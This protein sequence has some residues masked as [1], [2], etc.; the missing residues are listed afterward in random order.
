MI[1]SIA[2]RSLL[3]VIA[4]F[5][6][7]APLRAQ[8]FTV[9]ETKAFEKSKSLFQKGKYDKAI[10]TLNKVLYAHVHDAELWQHRVLFEKTRYDVEF[11][12]D[13]Q[14]IVK[15]ASKAG[16][17]TIDVSK[18]KSL[19]YRDE[20]L[21]ACYG[22][23]LYAPNQDLASL[24][25]HEN[26]IEPSVDTLISDEVKA[27]HDK[28]LQAQ[29]DKDNAEAMRQFEKAFRMDTTYYTAAVNI[30]YGYYTDEKFDKAVE[31]FRKA[32]RL[33][34]EM[35]EPH[36]YLVEI[37][38]D[39]KDWQ[40]A[41]DACLDAMIQYPFTGYFTRMERICENLNKTFKLHWMER[42]YFPAIATI[43]NQEQA[44]EQPWS[45]YTGAKDK[46]LGY[47]NDDGVVKKTNT[48]T[49]S[50]YMEVYSWE[51]MLKKSDED[52]GE[53]GFA[54]RQQEQGNLDCF[55]MFSMYHITFSAQYTHF[56]DNNR[57]RLKEYIETQLVR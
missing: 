4:V 53:M 22:A 36:F 17:A 3:F 10:T 2:V 41:Y 29:N 9:A 34:P 49:E 42:D 20:M 48:L 16:G 18:L 55:A 56:R 30:A 13:I 21:F 5:L 26:Y 38:M 44:T 23:T 12:K 6:I 11:E 40:G 32:I 27:V 8:S 14:F 25:L 24:M 54:R 43:Q 15:Q 31:W 51:Y 46:I 47:V 57:A 7:S 33:Q 45:F 37:Y 52:K 19:T 39:R 35:L 28:G 1:N 50:K